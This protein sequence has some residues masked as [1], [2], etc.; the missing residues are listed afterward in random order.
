MAEGITTTQINNMEDMISEKMNSL[1][2]DIIGRVESVSTVEPKLK[3][4]I[5][6]L[7]EK[8][9]RLRQDVN[10][11]EITKS[12]KLKAD[13]QTVD[14]KFA[15]L[16]QTGLHFE[17]FKVEVEQTLAS[18]KK[19][20]KKIIPCMNEIYT[21]SKDTIAARQSNCLVCGRS[22][23][24]KKRAQS[25]NTSYNCESKPKLPEL[26]SESF[27]HLGRNKGLE[28]ESGSIKEPAPYAQVVTKSQSFI[29][30]R[31]QATQST[32]SEEG[33][34][35]LLVRKSKQDRCST[36]FGN[37]KRYKLPLSFQVL[38][39]RYKETGVSIP[40]NATI[41]YQGT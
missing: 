30:S 20:V 17:S 4:M 41:K 32:S 25:P 1:V 37:R 31:H 14:K 6:D 2:G 9:I 40:V 33:G 3:R 15:S 18:L 27:N 38:N 29:H 13:A 8:I 22:D 7:D 11:H 24:L 35:V 10:P 19:A 16:E 28:A 39:E 12:I 21:A 34:R 5:V 36:A 23:A 26:I